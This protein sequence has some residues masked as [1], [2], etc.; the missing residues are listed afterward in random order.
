[1][2]NYKHAFPHFDDTLPTLA[3][4]YD[5]SWKNDACPSITK[6]L[7]NE[8]Y[9]QIFIDYKDQTKS[10]FYDVAKEHYSRFHVNLDKPNEWLDSK[11]LFSSND[12]ASVE[13]FIKGFKL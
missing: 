4:F 5:S 10:D 2:S 3:G 9:L 6:D 1:M 7:G 13:N 11:F 8:T 12:W